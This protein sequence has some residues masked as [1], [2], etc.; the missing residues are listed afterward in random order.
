MASAV[1]VTQ[2]R[3]EPPPYRDKAEGGHMVIQGSVSPGT[4]Q[5]GRATVAPSLTL[6]AMRRSRRLDRSVGPPQMS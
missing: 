3:R 1:S 4:I 2:G 5:N 6:Q